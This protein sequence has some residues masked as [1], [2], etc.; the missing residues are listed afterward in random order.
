MAEASD[1]YNSPPMISDERL[2]DIAQI[3]ASGQTDHNIK[4]IIEHENGFVSVF[5][6]N[7]KQMTWYQGHRLYVLS[8][9]SKIASDDV[10]WG[11]A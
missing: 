2:E 8:M 4:N 6:Q 1:Y 7:G 3:E 11:K 10:N 9:L 5:D